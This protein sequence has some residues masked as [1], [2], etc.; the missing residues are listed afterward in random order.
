MDSKSLTEQQAEVLRNRIGSMLGYVGRLQR[1]MQRLGW[2]SADPLYANV[3]AAE[4]ALHDLHV[5]LIYLAAP[6]GTAGQPAP[7]RRPWE[8]GGSGRQ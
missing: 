1:R 3:R 4:A 8:P 2:P 7:P 5:R 6:P